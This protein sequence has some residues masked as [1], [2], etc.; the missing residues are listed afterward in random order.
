MTR[1]VGV[2]SQAMHRIGKAFRRPPTGRLVDRNGGLPRLSDGV[3]RNLRCGASRRPTLLAENLGKPSLWVI[4][5][6]RWYYAAPRGPNRIT[7]AP[8]TQMTAPATSQRSGRLPSTS[9]NQP[10]EA[11]M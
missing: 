8:M 6:A 3:A 2:K 5:I 1:R 11:A 4:I 9:H 7:A 10:R